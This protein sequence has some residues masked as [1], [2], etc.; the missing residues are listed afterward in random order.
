MWRTQIAHGHPEKKR[1]KKKK[2]EK[3]KRGI[4]NTPIQLFPVRFTLPRAGKSLLIWVVI[5]PFRPKQFKHH[6]VAE[7]HNAFRPR[8]QLNTAPTR[9]FD[10]T[11]V[12]L[13]HRC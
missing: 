5:W 6:R 9:A 11:T 8:P 12:P 1:K 13:R 3:K 7:G 2:A 10:N 4:G